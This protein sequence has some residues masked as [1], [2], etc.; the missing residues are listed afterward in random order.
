MAHFNKIPS[1]ILQ[2]FRWFNAGCLLFTILV[3]IDIFILPYNIKEEK[4]LYRQEVYYTGQ[5]RYRRQTY[6]TQ[7]DNVFLITENFR[8]PYHKVQSFNPRAADSARM[9]TTKIFKFVKAAYVKT[10]EGEKELKQGASMFG[11]FMFI[12][13]IF[14]L[15]A[16]FGV[17][18]R[19]NS[20]QLSNAAIINII[21]IVIQLWI[22]GYF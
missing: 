10:D 6:R 5:T 2:L 15:T 1:F 17:S 19:H 9:V 16:L 12:P 21:L 4:I 7:L 8:F 18:M 11:T 14:A 22:Y 3:C 13:I 20:E